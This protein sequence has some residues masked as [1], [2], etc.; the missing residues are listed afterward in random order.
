MDAAGWPEDVC[1]IPEQEQLAVYCLQTG[2]VICRL[3]AHKGEVGATQSLPLRPGGRSSGL[4]TGG[5]DGRILLWRVAIT[6][7]SS[8]D[9][10]VVCLEDVISLD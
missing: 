9:A 8:D 3:A 7:G 6:G 10:D 4:L 2:G 5:Q 1:F